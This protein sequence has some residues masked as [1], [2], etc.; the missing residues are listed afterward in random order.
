MLSHRTVK[1]AVQGKL[2]PVEI[3]ERVSDDDDLDA[4]VGR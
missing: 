1:A 3:R 4:G 2:V